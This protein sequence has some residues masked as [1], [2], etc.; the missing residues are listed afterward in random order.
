MLKELKK[1]VEKIGKKMMYKQKRNNNREMEN[2]KRKQFWS[3]ESYN[4]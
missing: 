2:L 4:N 1:D 3:Y